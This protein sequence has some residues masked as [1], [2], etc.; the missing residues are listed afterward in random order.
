ML[1]LMVAFGGSLGAVARYALAN[2][3]I[4]PGLKF[5]TATL[6]ANI[7]GSFLMGMLFVFIVQKGLLPAAMRQFLMVGFL[8]AFT[9]FSTFS[10]ETLQFIQ[11]GL[12]QLALSYTLASFIGCLCA[13][14][15]GVKIAELFIN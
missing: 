4:T 11:N 6:I 10:I 8:G 5:P 3:L 12:W 15:S 14:Y 9:T 7:L 13:V 1:W 2:L